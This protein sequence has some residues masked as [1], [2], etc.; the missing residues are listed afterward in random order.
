MKGLPRW[1]EPY[2]GVAEEQ[3]PSASTALGSE[4]RARRA[5]QRSQT[6][7]QYSTTP[8]SLPARHFGKRC[9]HDRKSE[10]LFANSIARSRSSHLAY[11]AQGK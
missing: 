11:S 9:R 2:K 6:T 7:A 3:W 5:S 1:I 8:E 10:Q 4:A